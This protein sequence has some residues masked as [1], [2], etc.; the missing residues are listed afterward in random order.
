MDMEYYSKTLFGSLILC[1]ETLE[2]IAFYDGHIC[3]ES[4]FPNGVPLTNSWMPNTKSSPYYYKLDLS[5]R[6]WSKLYVFAIEGDSEN[7]AKLVEM[8]LEKKIN[9][10]TPPCCK[11]SSNNSDKKEIIFPV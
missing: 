4:F 3:R 6:D 1:P 8:E 10:N 5:I 9:E 2:G 11:I 7:G